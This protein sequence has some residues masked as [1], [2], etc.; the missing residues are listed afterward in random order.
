MQIHQLKP[1]IKLK[2]ERRV[3]RGDK[4]AGRG[5]KGQKARAGAKIRPAIRDILKKIP[6][7]R[8]YRFRSF[9]PRAVVLA[10]DGLEKHFPNGAT[11]DARA[12]LQKGL[13]ARMGKKIPA[14]KILGRAPLKK[15]F[16]FHGLAFSA[17]SRASVEAAGGT[18][19]D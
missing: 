4:T 17:S 5:T 6:K 14:I 7:R 8:G 2:R 9:R 12:L 16:I 15:Q 3:G 11:I 18:I 10:L 19:H 13:V 1:K